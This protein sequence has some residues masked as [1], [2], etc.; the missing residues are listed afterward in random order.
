M[1]VVE[2]TQARA[3]PSGSHA[4][5][6]HHISNGGVVSL[7]IAGAWMFVD[8]AGRACRLSI[9]AQAGSAVTST[10]PCRRR[11]SVLVIRTGYPEEANNSPLLT[12]NGLRS[13]SKH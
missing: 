3:L 1:L 4:A 11:L 7:Q 5:S 13:R 8:H 2:Q 9:P 10:A 6:L 12:Q